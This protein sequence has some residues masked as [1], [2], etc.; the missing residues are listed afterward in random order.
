MQHQRERTIL[1]VCTDPQSHLVAVAGGEA[2]GAVL[3]ALHTLDVLVAVVVGHL[4]ILVDAAGGQDDALGG[5]EQPQ[6]AVTLCEHAGHAAVLHQQLLSL[7]VEEVGGGVLVLFCVLAVLVQ[8]VGGCKVAALGVELM[9]ANV[10]EHV[11]VVGLG[12]DG[13]GGMCTEGHRHHTELRALV[14]QPVAGLGGVVEPHGDQSLVH[15]A[16]AALDPDVLVLHH[17]GHV[18]QLALIHQRLDVLGVAQTNTAAL[19]MDGVLGLNDHDLAAVLHAGAGS[20]TAGVAGT[21]DDHLS[22]HDLHGI[23]ILVLIRV[24]EE[25]GLAGLGSSGL[26]S[27]GAGSGCRSSGR[28]CGAA[29]G[30]VVAAG[31]HTQSSG[32]QC[33]DCGALEEGSTGQFRHGSFSLHLFLSSCI[34]TERLF[35]KKETFTSFLF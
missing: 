28:G 21:H 3:A 35:V 17:V 6:L 7:G 11:V 5:T 24:G 16:A 1:H 32:T 18:G 8:D 23:G 19:A 14:D 12:D 33:A 13:V 20:G 34:A 27:R 10:D 2:C 4:G 25:A 22:G 15:A 30:S 26:L 29:C 9:V 31:G